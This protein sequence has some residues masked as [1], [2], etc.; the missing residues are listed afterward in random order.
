MGEPEGVSRRRA[1]ADRFHGSHPVLCTTITQIAR[2]PRAR[3]IGARPSGCRT[4]KRNPF[5]RQFCSLKAALRC[6]GGRPFFSVAGR[7]LCVLFLFLALAGIGSRAH[8]AKPRAVDE[9]E[10]L[11]TSNAP[12]PRAFVHDDHI[13][14]YF[15]G[16]PRAVGFTAKLD[17]HRIQTDGYEVSSAWLRLER[18]PPPLPPHQDGWRE[19][20]VIAG[21]Q[22]RL[23]VTNLIAELT[24][25]SA[26]RGVYYRGF[27]GDRILYRDA[28]GAPRFAP[29]SQP[30][31]GVQVERRYSLE[32]TL[33]ILAHLLEQHLAQTHP[34]NSPFLL[35]AHSR[36][37]PQP[38]FLDPARHQ[39]A[40]V[41][42][43]ALFHS[44][45]PGVGLVRTA[46]GLSALIFE[47]HV[48]A[49]LKNPV[50][51]LARL[52]NLLVQTG[53]SLVRLPLPGP[54]KQ[55]PPLS[56]HPGMNLVEWENWL[57]HHTSTRRYEGSLE[58]LVDGERFFPRLQQAISNATDHVHLD[59]F[60]FDNDDV[61]VD[62]A[63]QLKQRSRQLLVQV[64]LDRL[65]S[66]AAA[67]VPPATPPRKDFT[68]PA[69]ITAY[70]KKNSK[71]RVRPFLNPFLSYDH[72][73]V[74]LIDGTRAWLG[75][76]NI[77]REYRYEWHDMMVEL[78]GPVVA[79]LELDFR[80]DWAHA[81]PLGDVTYLDALL[82]EKKAAKRYA[83]IPQPPPGTNQWTQMR[84][85]P[86]RT[87]WKPF[88][89]AVLASLA[90]AHSY[91]YVEN[92]YLFD[93]RVLNGLAAARSRGVDVRVILPHVNDS[94]TGSRVELI[95]SNYLL[96][97]GVRVYNY[98]GMT[99]VK[100]LLVDGWACAGSG[101]L[102]QFGLGL[103]QEH[104]V[105]TSDPA[106]AARLKHDLFEE[107]FS[108][109]YELTEPLSVEWM[110]FLADLVVEGF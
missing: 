73:K 64:I 4:R 9:W 52:G 68:P 106:F 85:L 40:W 35:M 55:I 87:T 14:I 102:N 45:E 39:C 20:L 100:T 51:S 98:P 83:A 5:I 104:N 50:S 99:H 94:P 71:V 36:R 81:G 17:R 10:R 37:F 23:L 58:L 74:Y 82:T 13:R 103:C 93:R 2:R 72:S 41:S 62:I 75:G 76:M 88:T 47:S 30:P 109:S 63:D 29:V 95:A 105:A 21:P 67:A 96:E 59:V 1:S 57:D 16:Q 22:W 110:D 11:T 44:T 107:D 108:H 42:P 18:K 48:L 3:G 78:H 46:R 12:P 24:P 91:I 38:L 84:L 53:S 33:Q 80:R 15:P 60:I 28:D 7:P 56:A 101:N 25:K 65:G 19:A 31:Q 32:E 92:A 6:R 69:S 86:T 66:I 34:T 54:P 89:K 77:G 79:A 97:H 8:A 70:L 49:L 90:K 27:L 61:A 26:G 43:A